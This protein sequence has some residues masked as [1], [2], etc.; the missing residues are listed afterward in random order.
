MIIET[1]LLCDISSFWISLASSIA[2]SILV[3][4]LLFFFFRP[5]FKVNK[6]IVIDKDGKLGFCFKTRSIFPCINIHVTVNKVKEHANDDES[7]APMTLQYDTE[8]LMKG[9]FGK[10]NESELGMFTKDPIEI[11]PQHI[12]IVIS[13]QHAVS[14]I[15]AAT[16]H[17]FVASDAKR[18]RFEKGIFVPDGSSY[19][20]EY[21]RMHLKRQ[22]IAFWVCLGIIILL[23]ILYAI[24]MS[25]SIVNTV[26]CF[27]ILYGFA[28]ICL[29]LWH[30]YV[31]ARA[32]AFSSKMFHKINLLLLALY[33]KA[34]NNE[35]TEDANYELVEDQKK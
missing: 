9:C 5:R 21:I 23:T 27:I 10:E 2:G 32:D 8:A 18:G 29:I 28:T 34:D 4:F 7:E 19:A 6:E 15:F 17:N 22:R 14:G 26:L 35:G 3:I 25:A 24:L 20:Q 30:I 33:K 13:A 1:I 11:I 12:R 31:L 16:T